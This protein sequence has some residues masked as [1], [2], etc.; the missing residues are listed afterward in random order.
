MRFYVKGKT[1]R[2][3]IFCVEKI[4]KYYY[5]DEHILILGTVIFILVTK[6]MEVDGNFSIVFPNSNKKK[7]MMTMTEE[8]FFSIDFPKLKTKIMTEEGN[9]FIDFPN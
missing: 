3:T 2:N 9:F 5:N 8:G 4:S 7:I 1:K 6:N